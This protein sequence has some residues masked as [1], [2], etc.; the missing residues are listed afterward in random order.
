[1][2]VLSVDGIELYYEVEGTGDWVVFVHGGGGSHLDWYRQTYALR[3]RFRCVT[4]DQRGLGRSTG[5]EDYANADR[6][7]LALMDELGIEKAHLNGHSGGGWAVAKLAQAH[8]ERVSSLTMSASPFGFQ[9]AA[10]A[11]WAGE[12]LAKLQS[13]FD[14]RNHMH[15]PRFVAAQPE[16]AYL[17]HAIRRASA[18]S[19]A[20]GGTGADYL[21]VYRA[22]Q[23]APVLDYSGFAVP[24]LFV[25]GSEDQLTVP[26]VIRGTAGEVAG[27]RLREIPDAGHYLQI[28]AADAYNAVLRDFLADPAAF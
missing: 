10:L 12:M 21:D 5:S 15:G 8:P 28:E 26:S 23:R 1:M 7:L 11:R 4:F 24:A 16:L 22:M 3:G 13:G 14:I 6:E 27:A 19:A 2:P 25:V 17:H 18:H 9:T 20:A